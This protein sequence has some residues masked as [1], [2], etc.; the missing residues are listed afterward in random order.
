MPQIYND[1]AGGLPST[2]GKQFRTDFYQK[3]ALLEAKKTQFFG[4]MA[5]TMNMPKN[6][7]KTIKRYHYLPLLDDANINDQGIDA[8]G[9]TTVREVSIAI[10]SIDGIARIPNHGRSVGNITYFVGDGANATA[11]E[12]AAVLTLIN[13]AQAPI[14][15][16]G[17]G[18]TLVGITNDLKF[19]DAVNS[20]NG[21]AYLKGY[22]FMQPD[23]ITVIQA[24]A[25]ALAAQSVPA[26][27]NL[28]GS[29]KDVGYIAGKLPLISETGGFKNRVGFKRIEVTGTL[30]KFG[31]Y[32]EYTQESIDFDTDA[33]LEMH[34]NRE[35]VLG[36]SEMTEDA[37]QIDLLNA[38]GV[39]RFGGIAT[40]TSEITGEGANV[41]TINYSDLMRLAVDLDD[42]RTPK[43]TKLITGTRIIDTRVVNAAR[44]MYVGSELTLML[45]EMT[46]N[47]A[48]AQ[49]F[50]SVEKYGAATT[51]AVGEI[52][53]IDQFRIIVVPEM[54]H[55]EA[56]GATATGANIGYRETNG[57]YDVFP[58]LVVGSGSFTTVGF[59][60]DGKSVKFKIKHSKPGSPE[61]FASDPFGETGFMSIKWYYGTMILRPERIA[62]VKVAAKW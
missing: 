43:D 9:V 39:I 38:A 31:F 24:A 36:A 25:G 46:T 56:A 14:V 7:G 60:T 52:G 54:M 34:I 44:Y 51:I 3:R 61:S 59:Q 23:G 55:W 12:T 40:Q 37:L 15:A 41:S 21:Q 10:T 29:S 18:L 16:G 47:F 48:G 27:G 20:T 45:K 33:E 32:D 6:M 17:L 19:A 4:Q 1:P 2:V 53:V 30:A 62:L 49:A 11:A 5:D 26:S 58:M 35:M 22:R 28:Y 8:N 42:N 13:W 57:K 50:V